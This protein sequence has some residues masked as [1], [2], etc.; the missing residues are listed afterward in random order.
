MSD[1]QLNLMLGRAIGQEKPD[2]VVVRHA[3]HFQFGERL[4][5]DVDRQ[6]GGGF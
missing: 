4:F 1:E 5:N 3:A 6:E 2:A